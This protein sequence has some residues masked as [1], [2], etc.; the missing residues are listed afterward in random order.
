MFESKKMR[1]TAILGLV[2]V[3][4]VSTVG[5]ASAAEFPEG[6]TIPAGKTIDD[7]VFL[8]GDKVVVDGTVNGILIAAGQTVTLN[9][10]IN[11]D[12][13]LMGERVLVNDGAVIEGNLFLGAADIELNGDVMGST[14]GGSADMQIGPAA[15][16]ARNLFYGGF[17]LTTDAGSSVGKDLY[18]GNYQSLLSGEI[19]RDLMVGAGAL[20]LDSAV[21]R[22]VVIETD[23]EGP[24]PSV[25]WMKFNPSISQYVTEFV[26]PGVRVSDK[27]TI[28][29][30]VRYVSP[31]DNSAIFEDAA[32]GSVTYQ[33]RAPLET[34]EFSDFSRD[35][36]QPFRRAW[37]GFAV[38]AKLF[39]AVRNFI[40]LMAIGAIILWLLRKPFMKLVEA[41]YAS[42]M[43]AMGWGFI[44]V[45]AGFLA[46][47]IVP[48]IFVLVGV[49]VGIVSLGSLLWVWFGL[50]GT[51]LTLA[52]LLFLFAVFTLSKVIAAYMF[53]RWIMKAVFKE[54]S[55]KVWPNLLIGVF[56]YALIRA[57][58]ILGF[59]AG[60][61][62]TLIGT[63]AFWLALQKKK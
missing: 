51:A 38:H 18:T 30:T 36:V 61:T 23:D 3:M 17:S 5:T 2:F 29:G 33:Y 27:A 52:G 21:G 7:D 42:P 12:A 43:K 53:G 32:A 9:G 60:V 31:V 1:W 16:I 63:G 44:V 57:I 47:L 55:E 46:A 4:L 37:P 24:D 59:L 22:N 56:L 15:E 40:K 54:E 20:E 11:G 10:T 58:P 19:G 49:L 48:L 26:E 8:T 34:E 25:E 6:G 41:A 50:A 28:K 14:F 45:G 39:G 13:F 35:S 62:A